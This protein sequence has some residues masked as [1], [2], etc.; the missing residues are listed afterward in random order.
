MAKKLFPFVLA[1]ILMLGALSVRA[2]ETVVLGGSFSFVRPDA[3]EVVELTEDDTA[4][5]MV[6][7]ATSDE[8]EMYV[9]AF[10]MEEMSSD[11]LYDM[12]REDEWLTGVKVETV[13]GVETLTYSIDEEGLGATIIGGDGKYYELMFYCL[14]DDAA[15][16]AQA[17]LQSLVKA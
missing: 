11:E 17:I 2:E 9:W 1:V 6:Y 3:L 12:Y 13:G 16:Q 5:G 15:T 8:L 7:A 14:T 4:E 10:E